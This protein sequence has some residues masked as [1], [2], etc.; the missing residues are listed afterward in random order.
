MRI[1]GIDTKGTL[2]VERVASLPTWTSE[3]EGRV[4][5]NEADYQLYYGDNSHWIAQVAQINRTTG[6]LTG[7]LITINAD[8]TKIDISAGTSFYVDNSNI[9][10]PVYDK[11]SWNTQTGLTPTD[12]STNGRLWVGVERTS[13][14]VG[15]I[16]FA[17]SFTPKQLRTIAVLGR[18]WANGSSTIEGVGRYITPAFGYEKIV[19]DLSTALGSINIDGNKF[20]PNGSNLLLDKSAGHAYRFTANGGTDLDSPN[21][22]SD[23]AATAISAYHY[24]VPSGTYIT[25]LESAIDP[26]YYDSGGV[27]TAT[28][29]SKWTIQRI[30]YFPGSGIVD[31][32]YGQY[33]YNTLDE[34]IAALNSENFTIND[35]NAKALS[36][37]ILRC[38]LLVKQGCTNLSDANY[39]KFVTAVGQGAAASGVPGTSGTSGSSGTSGAAG[40]SGSSGT[41][42]T[43][44]NGSSGSSGTSGTSPVGGLISRYLHTQGTSGISWSVVHNLGQKYVNVTVFNSSDVVIEPDTITMVDDNNLTITFGSSGSGTSGYALVL[45]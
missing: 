25:S 12:L 36:G 41:S 18:V 15:S 4:V 10:S 16:V 39:A 19:D 14:G 22:L 31:V 23:S 28:P 1:F 2:L 20:T 40:T 7:G 43:G 37:A 3:D 24:H 26:N 11:L 44:T 27:K 35:D 17:T 5:Y 6:V 34:T 45:G 32:L 21:I 9:L 8:P 30:Y 42:G 29:N 38:Y 13:P 33:S